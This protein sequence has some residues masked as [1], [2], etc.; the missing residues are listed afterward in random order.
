MKRVHRLK[1]NNVYNYLRITVNDSLS[2]AQMERLGL[3]LMLRKKTKLTF[4]LFND[5]TEPL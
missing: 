2:D 4:I 1:Y 3:Q 5:K